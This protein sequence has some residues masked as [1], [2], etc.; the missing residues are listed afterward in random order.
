MRI[1]RLEFGIIKGQGSWGYELT[2]CKCRIV[3]LGR[4]YFTWLDKECK[5]AACKKYTCVCPMS[6]EEFKEMVNSCGLSDAE[7]AREFQVSIT[8]VRR[9]KNGASCPHPIMR[10]YVKQFVDEKAKK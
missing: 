5:C 9:W 7:F 1:G 3:S 10:K 4:L 6:E 8:T 2:S